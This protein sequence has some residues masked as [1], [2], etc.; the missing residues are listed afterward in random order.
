M[1]SIAQPRSFFLTI[2]PPEVRI[3]VYR[4]II[5]GF[6]EDR[7]Q[8]T[9]ALSSCKMMNIELEHEL[10]RG[11]ISTIGPVLE[12]V[13]AAWSKVFTPFRATV[14][15]YE[16]HVEYNEITLILELPRSAFTSHH[17]QNYMQNRAKDLLMPLMALGLDEISISLFEDAAYT[18][19][20]NPSHYPIHKKAVRECRLLFERFD[21]SMLNRNDEAGRVHPYMSTTENPHPSLVGQVSYDMGPAESKQEREAAVK[22]CMD[23]QAYGV[24]TT[25]WFETAQGSWCQQHQINKSV[26]FLKDPPQKIEWRRFKL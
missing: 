4:Y 22:L 11:V 3:N 23:V 16:R 21:S 13:T 1:V 14:P 17:H 2:F 10:A 7:A 5:V 25:L 24:D 20:V 8:I 19:R 26:R 15:V 6:H 18:N 9:G 12:K